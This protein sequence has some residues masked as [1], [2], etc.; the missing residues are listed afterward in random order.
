MVR[1]SLGGRVR[2]VAP[3]AVVRRCV[4]DLVANGRNWGPMAVA[5]VCGATG[6]CGAVFGRVLNATESVRFSSSVETGAT[7]ARPPVVVAFMNLGLDQKLCSSAHALAR[8]R[9]CEGR[10]QRIARLALPRHTRCRIVRVAGASAVMYGAAVAAL[11]DTALW[12]LCM[13]S[14]RAL[15]HTRF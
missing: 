13:Q 12:L 5:D 11:S 4:D 9:F 7:H 1:A 8:V 6:R 10:F 3:G 15:L 2:A 14:M